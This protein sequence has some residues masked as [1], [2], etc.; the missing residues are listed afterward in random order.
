M[1]RPFRRFRL[2]YIHNDRFSSASR[3]KIHHLTVVNSIIM[4]GFFCFVTGSATF[5]KGNSADALAC[6]LPHDPGNLCCHG[7]SPTGQPFT[8][9]SPFA[10]A[11]AIASHP[12]YPQPPQLFPG[13]CSLTC[14]SFSSI[15]TAN[16]F[17]CQSKEKSQ[18][19]SGTSYDHSRKY[20]L[21][22]H[23]PLLLPISDWKIQRMRSPSDRL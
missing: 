7:I 11:F 9:A 12:A 5:Y 21:H 4:T 15:S 20:D 6:F 8:G 3:N 23:P 22:A 1:N 10:I 14:C 18:K 19:Q 17:P 13:S 16:F 2:R